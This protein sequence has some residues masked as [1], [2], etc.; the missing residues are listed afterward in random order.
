MADYNPLALSLTLLFAFSI[1]F[2]FEFSLFFFLPF[3]FFLSLASQ[4]L[5]L[6]VC[7]LTAFFTSPFSTTAL[8]QS[9]FKSQFYNMNLCTNLVSAIRKNDENQA[10]VINVKHSST[11]LKPSFNVCLCLSPKNLSSVMQ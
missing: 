3:L 5:S 1:S 6:L 9:S 7:I 4:P 11:V 2:T 8:Y 10:S